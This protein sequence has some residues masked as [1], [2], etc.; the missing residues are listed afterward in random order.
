MV[1]CVVLTINEEKNIQRC[2][3][4][5]EWCD[6]VIVIDDNSTD[7]TVEYAKKLGARIFHRELG[8]NFSAQRNYGLDKATGE[9]VLFVDADE[10]VSDSLK[11]EILESIN[12]KDGINGFYIKRQDYVWGKKIKHGE[13]G[14]ISLL[15]LARKGNGKW[16]GRVHEEWKIKGKIDSLENSLLHYPHKDINEFL[17]KINYYTDIRAY[18]LFEK[19]VNTNFLSIVLYTKAKFIQNYFLKLGVLDG[20]PGLILA[21]LMSLHSFLVRGKLWLLWQKK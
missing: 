11:K 19:G 9:W 1:S 8:N 18:E 20:I 10:I 2:L 16:E 6:E 21:I 17:K 13:A 15:R 12:S 5:L 4:G 14:K 3:K 7:K